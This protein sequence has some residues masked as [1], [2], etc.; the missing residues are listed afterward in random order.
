MSRR[1]TVKQRRAALRN[2]KKARAALRRGK[3]RRGR[4]IRTLS[5]RRAVA[6]RYRRK[7]K[8]VKVH[9]RRKAGRRKA[10][11]KF[12][13]RTGIRTGRKGTIS[14][15]R[16]RKILATNPRRRKG[17]RR[18][19]RSNPAISAASWKRGIT[20]I[21]RDVPALFRG[22]VVKNLA[23]AT[24]G[25]VGALVVGGMARGVVMGA[26]ARVAPAL[27]AN[28]IAQGVLGAALS[29]SG[30]YAAGQ[31]LIKGEQARR[32]FITG[33]AAAAIINA[34]MP[35]QVNAMLVRIPVLGPMLAN[36][37]GMSGL[38]AYVLAPASQ[39]IGSYVSAP[40]YQGVGYDPTI[41][42]I[43]YQDD[44]LAGELGAY[45]TAPAS[46]SM[47]GMRSHLDR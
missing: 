20:Q 32:A 4:R 30:G 45:V 3:S 36:L 14:F 43:G 39:S 37:P 34:L 35:G 33:A 8:G 19:R 46:Q 10:S 44:A 31:M 26:V 28:K 17:K 38:G 1:M 16:R 13:R 12:T 47:G 22:K 29:Y 27:A 25:A 11:R 21:H 40:S 6:K 18:G 24:G 41:A 5:K 23:F 2:L 42:G 9:V 15:L 7:L